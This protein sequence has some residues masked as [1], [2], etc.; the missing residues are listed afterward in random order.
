MLSVSSW[1]IVVDISWKAA[2]ADVRLINT[3]DDL[4]TPP[5]AKTDANY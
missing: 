3:S 4:K 1:A 5:N 2:F